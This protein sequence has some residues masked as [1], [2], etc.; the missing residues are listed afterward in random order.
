MMKL[1]FEVQPRPLSETRIALKPL[2]HSGLYGLLVYELPRRA[3][4]Q[5]QPGSIVEATISLPDQYPLHAARYGDGREETHFPL[6]WCNIAT[7]PLK[8][9]ILLG[10]FDYFGPGKHAVAIGEGKSAAYPPAVDM[11]P[12]WSADLGNG[13]QTFTP[14][15]WQPLP[16]LVGN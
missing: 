11:G 15:H 4:E 13:M 9:R 3:A 10:A 12:Y 6:P 5:M 8:R 2:D 16:E 14:T 1:K 7:A